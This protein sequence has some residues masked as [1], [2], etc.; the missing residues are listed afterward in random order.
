[1]GTERTWKIKDKYLT[2]PVP[3]KKH[4]PDGCVVFITSVGFKVLW[5][6]N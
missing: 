3:G 1:M 2:T 5:M 4:S 6:H